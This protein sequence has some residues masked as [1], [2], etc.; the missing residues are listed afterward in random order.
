MADK[1]QHMFP[2]SKD[3]LVDLK[4][5]V[6]EMISLIEVLSFA[7][8][9]YKFIGDQEQTKGTLAAADRMY[10]QAEVAH[11]LL[12]KMVISTQVADAKGTPN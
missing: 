6:P 3:G 1:K 5:T 10:T 11:I 8:Q 2:I 7:A 4:M 12:D 9:T